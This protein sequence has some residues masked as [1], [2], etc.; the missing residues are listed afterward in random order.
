LTPQAARLFPQR[1]D[2]IVEGLLEE[3]KSALP[4]EQVRT[5]FLHMAHKTASE[6]PTPSP[7]QTVEER[8][9]AVADF[10][11]ARGYNARWEAKNGHYELHACN[12][13][14]AGTADRHHELCLM[15]QELMHILLPGAT[16]Y[17]TRA[18][19]GATHCTYVIE[20]VPASAEPIVP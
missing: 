13:P 17:R 8:L 10:L 5:F 7:D 14:Y 18:L 9:A 4:V 2:A 6:A 1:H 11:T 3:I 20:P 16:R 15:D 12:C 19:H